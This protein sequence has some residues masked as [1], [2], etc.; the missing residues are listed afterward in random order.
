MTL[1]V[2]PVLQQMYVLHVMMGI[3][4]MEIFVH[5]VITVYVLLVKYKIL[6]AKHLVKQ[7]VKPVLPKINVILVRMDI[8]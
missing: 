2:K 8:I 1:A 3:I 4:K 6:T 5:N 7:T